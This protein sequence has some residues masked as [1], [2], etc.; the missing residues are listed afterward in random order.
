MRRW[1]IGQ[2]VDAASR[3]FHDMPDAIGGDDDV[4]YC[5]SSSSSRS[6]TLTEW[7]KAAPARRRVV[8]HSGAHR[9]APTRTLQA[10]TAHET[11]HGVARHARTCQLQVATLAQQGRWSP[12]LD[13]PLPS[14]PL[15]SVAVKRSSSPTTLA[16][17]TVS[18]VCR[19]PGSLRSDDP[20]RTE[21][22]RA[23]VPQIRKIFRGKLLRRNHIGKNE[24]P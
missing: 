8:R 23:H 1:M 3:I 22:L 19:S 11:L 2:A 5:A 12:T 7:A 4:V 13:C 20:A 15:Q 10:Q 24:Q 21:G 18:P 16:P 9:L 14:L 6:R 17:E